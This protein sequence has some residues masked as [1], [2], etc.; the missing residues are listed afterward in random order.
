MP[1]RKKSPVTLTLDQ[2]WYLWC[3]CGATD[4]SPFCDAA[5]V[6]LRPVVVNGR[7]TRPRPKAFKVKKDGDEVTL[8]RCLK[9][10]TP[11]FCDGTHASL[12]E[13]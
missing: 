2:G 11:P 13:S 1:P 10:A 6:K 5:H 8:C 12:S 4:R 3:S 7:K 9:T